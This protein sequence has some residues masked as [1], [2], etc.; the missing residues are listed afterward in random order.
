M[1]WKFGNSMNGEE[2]EQCSM[3][4]DIIGKIYFSDEI[5]RIILD[6]IFGWFLFDYFHYILLF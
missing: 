4:I 6:D 3:L 2:I 1:K 5:L